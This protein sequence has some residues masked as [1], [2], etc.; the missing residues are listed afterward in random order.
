MFVLYSPH[1]L[2]V[3]YAFNQFEMASYSLI[4]LIC[5]IC[6]AAGG[7]GTVGTLIYLIV[8]SKKKAKQIDTVQ[9][10]QSHQLEALYVPDIRLN[11]Y[12]Y[13]VEGLI[14]NELVF[15]N[16][17]DDLRLLDVCSLTDV[18]ILNTEGMKGWF[19]HDFD[20]GS[21]IHVPLS[22]QLVDLQGNHRIGLVCINKLGLTYLVPVDIVDG[23]PMVQSPMLQ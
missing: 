21:D 20:K 10:I 11:F 23:K 19:P 4:D 14:Q 3:I 8:D 22:I 9:K 5:N 12:S 13:K 6:M 7:V 16:H 17:G 15:S 1:K 2:H 18:K